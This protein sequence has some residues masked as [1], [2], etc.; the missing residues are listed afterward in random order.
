[1]TKSENFPKVISRQ[2]IFLIF[3]FVAPY[4]KASGV[5]MQPVIDP[6]L[7]IMPFLFSTIFGKTKW[8]ILAIESALQL[9]MSLRRYSLSI[10]L[11][12]LNSKLIPTLFTRTPT[13]KLLSSFFSLSY[14]ARGSVKS[15]AIVRTCTEF[16]VLVSKEHMRG[17]T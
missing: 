13:S 10:L 7:I 3:T 5:G 14:V 12:S 11:S 1:M 9:T 2:R 17:A 6:T 8:H 15:T 4:I 16:F